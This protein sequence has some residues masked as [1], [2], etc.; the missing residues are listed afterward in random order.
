MFIHLMKVNQQYQ[1]WTKN[2]DTDLQKTFKARPNFI[3]PEI[4]RKTLKLKRE[5]SLSCF[6]KKQG[7]IVLSKRR[8]YSVDVF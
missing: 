7:F 3:L 6:Y 8:P 4:E 2:W 5:G 1:V